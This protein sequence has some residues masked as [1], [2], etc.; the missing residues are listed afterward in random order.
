MACIPSKKVN[1]DEASLLDLKQVPGM[2]DET[3]RKILEYRDQHGPIREFSD[4][5]RVEGV[6]EDIVDGLRDCLIIE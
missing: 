4:L 2:E 6:N 5:K 3:A 1:I